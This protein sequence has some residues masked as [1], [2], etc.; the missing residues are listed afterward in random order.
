MSEEIKHTVEEQPADL[1]SLVEKN[2]QW[3]QLIYEQNKKI[4]RRLTLMVVAKYVWI[5]IIL[6]PAILGFIY[7]PAFLQDLTKNYGSL[8]ESVVKGQ[9]LV[10][11]A[12]IDKV[13][14]N[15]N[16]NDLQVIIKALGK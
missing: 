3:S 15:L 4:Q 6:V 2:L 12:T 16:Q 11:G 1:K 7:L 9:G 5:V 10:S 14:N 8:L 13:V